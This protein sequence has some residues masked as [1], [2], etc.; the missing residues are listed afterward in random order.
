[1]T[2]YTVMIDRNR[3]GEVE[4]VLIH[5]ARGAHRMMV[6]GV[7]DGGQVHYQATYTGPEEA[8]RWT[9]S[10][11]PLPPE[12]LTPSGAVAVSL[13]LSAAAVASGERPGG[14]PVTPVLTRGQTLSTAVYA[15]AADLS[16]AQTW[17][18]A[19]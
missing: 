4:E 15:V 18:G 11:Q 6:A 16:S 7:T 9:G 13:L 1:M 12:H 5:A 8:A 3:I 2:R 19:A 14:P 10:G 17:D